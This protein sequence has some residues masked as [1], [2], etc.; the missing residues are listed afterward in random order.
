[1]FRSVEGAEEDSTAAAQ[2]LRARECTERDVV[3][4]ITAGGTTPFVHG[5]IA[6]AREVGALSVFFACVPFEQATDQADISIRVLTGP[7][8]LQGSTRLKAGTATKLALNSISTLVMTQLGKVHDNRMVDVNTAGNV[9]LLDRGIRL[10]QDLAEVDRATA[11]QGLEAAKGNAKLAI[12]MLR[13]Q[14]SHSAAQE[15]LERSRG[16][17]RL[18]LEDNETQ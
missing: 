13:G 2:E 6:L 18:A 9:K 5:A 3:F 7:E 16:H 4:G 12:L 14:L 15:R 8:V 11:E 17:L 10:V 1:M